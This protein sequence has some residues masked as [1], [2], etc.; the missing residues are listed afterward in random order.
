MIDLNIT[1]LAHLTYMY[2]Q[3]MIKK[4][5]GKILNVS[6]IAAFYPGPLQPIYYATKA[7]ELSFTQAIANELANTNITVSVLC[8]GPVDT[9]FAQVAGLKSKTMGRT[10]L[11]TAEEIAICGYEGMLNGKH[12]IIP[13]FSMKLL[14]ILAR[15][16]PRDLATWLSRKLVDESTL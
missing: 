7:F 8:P 3:D 14:A 11:S 4:N 2:L 15:F 12:V 10:S 6:S 16:L 9:E 13:T 5:S 1:A